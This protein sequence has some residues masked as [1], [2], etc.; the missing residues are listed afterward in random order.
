VQ[1]VS[2]SEIYQ[3][4]GFQLLEDERV[5]V[6]EPLQIC[7]ER[8]SQSKKCDKQLTHIVGVAIIIFINLFIISILTSHYE[9]VKIK[10]GN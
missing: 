4:I 9:K 7:F 6:L 1:F 10:M 2:E 8:R 3:G 5:R